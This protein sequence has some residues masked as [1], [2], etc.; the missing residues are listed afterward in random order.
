LP[1]NVVCVFEGEEE[2][3]SPNLLNFVKAQR[4]QLACDVAVMADACMASDTRPAIVH[5]MRGALYLE[6]DVFGPRHDLHSGN[7]GGAIH[8]PLQALCELVAALHDRRGRIA[9]PGFYDR[10]R[11]CSDAERAALSRDAPAAEVILRD[12]G[13]SRAWG[14]TG[15]SVY[16]RLALRPALTVNGLSGG[17]SGP[18]TKGVIPAQASAKL[19]FRLV[20]DQDPAE[21]DQLLRRH[22]CTLTPPSVQ[23]R[24]RTLSAARPA[25]VD[26]RHPAMAAAAWACREAFGA[27]PA[28]LR[29]GGTIPALHAFAS[30]LGAPSVLL[31]FAPTDAGLHAPDERLH[32]PTFHKAVAAV[33]WLLAALGRTLA[34]RRGTLHAAP[35]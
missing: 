20:P 6:L 29:G 33:I 27:P 15:Y 9:V 30:V 35:A 17:Y 16:E 32:L 7:F 8:N 10:V 24:L 18:G 28:W 34:P 2:V 22:L 12:A 26:L 25:L 23:L 4:R 14:E 3:G 19:S 13:A 5:G 1:V 31:G 11:L 21:I